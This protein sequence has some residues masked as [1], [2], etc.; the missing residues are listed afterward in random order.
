V[1][2]TAVSD[3]SSRSLVLD[4]YQTPDGAITVNEHGDFVDPYFA[5]RALTLADENGM[6]VRAVAER[7][8]RWL[9]ARQLADGRFE[10]YCQSNGSDWSP[11]KPAD[12]DDAGLAVWLELLYRMAPAS[13]LPTAWQAS[14]TRANR[15]LESLRDPTSAL[16]FVSHDVR[17]SLLMDNVEV[18]HLFRMMAEASRRFGQRKLGRR[19]DARAIRLADAIWR[20]LWSPKQADFQASTQEHAPATFYPANVAQVYPWLFEMPTLA[21]DAKA[22]F[23]K[24]LSSYGEIWL[25]RRDDHFPWGVIAL[26]GHQVGETACVDRWI[27][28]SK[29][30]RH[31]A[32][33]T[34][35][36]EA[37]LQMLTQDSR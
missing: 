35:L 19:Y 29:S 9:M 22:A 25:D 1:L 12:A 33:W 26:A 30:L 2:A 5:N 13:G 6:D 8:I 37:V 27:E 21:G 15:H 16:Y 28:N 17:V 24:W 23:R 10:R 36:D 3:A 20:R 32:Y 4:L 14:A 31:S 18:Y 11:C 34:V 7:W